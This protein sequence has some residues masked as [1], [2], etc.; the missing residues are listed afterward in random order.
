MLDYMNFYYFCHVAHK[1]FLFVLVFAVDLG[2]A[3]LTQSRSKLQVISM[4]LGKKNETFLVKFMA[5]AQKNLIQAPQISWGLISICLDS[6]SATVKSLKWCQMAFSQQS[7]VQRGQCARS[8][9]A[10]SCEAG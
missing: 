7:Y 5:L 2:F 4:H 3:A 6:C 10:A 9:Q 8:K 1:N